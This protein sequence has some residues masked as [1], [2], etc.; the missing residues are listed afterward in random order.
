MRDL[1]TAGGPTTHILIGWR[2][3]V[4]GRKGGREKEKTEVRA[5]WKKTDKD[6]QLGKPTSSP[7]VSLYSFTTAAIFS[8]RPVWKERQREE[9][10]QWSYELHPGVQSTSALHVMRMLSFA[11][12]ASIWR[13]TNRWS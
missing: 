11:Q 3:R 6:K 10:V 5:R 4:G 9:T 7:L 12:V 8:M 13:F 1:P 2:E